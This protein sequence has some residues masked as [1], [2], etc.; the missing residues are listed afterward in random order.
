MARTPLGQ[1]LAR[2]AAQH[3]AADALDLPL[4]GVQALSAA[5]LREGLS[6]RGLLTGAAVVVGAAVLGELP[7]AARAA[8]S[9]RIAIVGAG[10]GGLSAALRLQDSGVTST[11][12]EANSRI[13]GR[14]YSNTTTWAQGQVSEWGGELVDTGHKTIQALARRFNIPLDNLVQ[15]EPSSAEPT[16]FFGGAYYPFSTATSDFQAVHQA[17]TNDLH[18]FTWPVT[19]DSHTPAGVALAN[20]SVYDWIESRVPGGHASSMGKL[21]DVAYNIEY[22]GETRD[23]TSLN[24]LGLLGYQPSPG[25]FSI[26]GLSDEKYHLRGG[27]QQLPAAIAAALPAGSISTGWTL[28]KLAQNANGTQTLT[29]TVGGSTRTVTADHTILALPIG[30]LQTL[31]FTAARFDSRKTGQIA[32]MRMGSNAKLQLQFSNRLWN[33]T[34]SWPGVS[35]GESYADT[36]Y[37]NT[38]D[39]TRAQSGS[40]GILVDYTGGNLAGAFNAGTPFSDQT[41][42]KVT[43]YAQ[44]F[45]KQVEPV[46]PGITAAW[47]GRATLSAW[48]KNPYSWGAYSYWPTGYCQNY[49]GYERV[50]QAN[51]HF[52][53]EHCSID[54]QGYMEGGAAEGQRAAAEI[55]ADYGLK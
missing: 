17:V 45:L 49:A 23:Q 14:M 31:D 36:G 24:L 9:R 30:V 1:S 33:Q 4:A 6:R 7:T 40:Q 47:T 29:F 12:Y 41:N 52:A 39:V 19:W 20:L 53:G 5:E 38:W 32:S 46:F 11:V 25:N 26:F 22:G 15:A 42:T 21:L 48:P 3:R 27:N 28:T 16:Y 34:G 44:A 18:T 10:I 2:L 43:A 54:F 37:Q 55:L 35:N 50:R 51:T 13:G 8:S